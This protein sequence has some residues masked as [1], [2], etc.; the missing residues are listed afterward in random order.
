VLTIKPAPVWAAM[1]CGAAIGLLSGLTGTGGGIF[2]APLLLFMGW[3]NIKTTAGVSSAFVLANSVASIAGL[4]SFGSHLP[5]QLSYWSVAVA[6]GALT[7]AEVGSR[8]LGSRT[9]RWLLA[10]VLTI[11]AGKLFFLP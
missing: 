7:G 5:E 6:V 8:W 9:L 10:A 2:L 3:A 1:L 11:A 4:L